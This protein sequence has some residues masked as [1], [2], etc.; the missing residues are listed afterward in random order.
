[1]VNLV[2]A[3]NAEARPVI[4]HFRL[5]RLPTRDRF[6]I[7]TNDRLRLV[8]SGVGRVAVAAATAYL[9]AMFSGRKSEGWLNAG[10]AGHPSLELGT[11]RLVHK[12]VEPASGKRWYPVF[13]AQAVCDSETLHTVDAPVEDYPEDVLY[14]MEA[15]AFF[16]TAVSFSTAELVHCLKVVS[17][18]RET[19]LLDTA[20][21]VTQLIER[22]VSLLERVVDSLRKEACEI[23]EIESDPC[24]YAHLID[25]FRFTTAERHRLL[26]LL[27]AKRA[28]GLEDS[29]PSVECAS[30][31]EV[32]QDLERELAGHG[33]GR[34]ARE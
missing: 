1:M 20:L 24:E 26:R 34:F 10:I 29:R 32:L 7:Y 12:I 18:N 9:R 21:A 33:V 25:R 31:R 27:R 14:D 6:R 23:A 13:S 19:P 2:I 28:L 30:G 16:A 15:S 5:K 8:V 17:D 22:H 11:A 3:L 4:E